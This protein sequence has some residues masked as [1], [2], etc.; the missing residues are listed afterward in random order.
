MPVKKF[1]E[2]NEIGAAPALGDRFAILDVSDTTE[3]AQ[4]TMK[5]VNA[6]RVARTGTANTFEADQTIANA[7]SPALGLNRTGGEQ[8]V[9]EHNSVLGD[10]RVRTTNGGALTTKVQLSQAGMLSIGTTASPSTLGVNGDI[11]LVDGMT[12]PTATSGFAK[13]Y[14]D[15]ADGDLKI[16]FGDGTT[17]TI[18][19]DT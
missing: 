11:A 3:S 19:T 12:A 9:L 8:I 6:S 10:F 4:G 15:S 2:M 18:V 13:L 17:K 16:R 7:S 14:V 1:S 5:T